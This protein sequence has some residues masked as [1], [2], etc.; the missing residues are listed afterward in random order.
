MPLARPGKNIVGTADTPNVY[1]SPG[2]YSRVFSAYDSLGKN[3]ARMGDE[4]AYAGFRLDA[5]ERQDE[6]VKGEIEYGRMYNEHRA[7]QLQDPDYASWPEKFDDWSKQAAARIIAQTKHPGA[8]NKLADILEVYK[9]SYGKQTIV[10]ASRLKNAEI[11]SR[12]PALV[13]KYVNDSVELD[14]KNVKE[15]R[16]ELHQEL[17]VFQSTGTIFS[18]EVDDYLADF[19]K[20]IGPVRE[21]RI[22]ENA[23]GQVA[24]IINSIPQDN[25]D[26]DLVEARRHKA[27]LAVDNLALALDRP[28]RNDLTAIVKR[29]FDAL[30][31]EAIM[32]RKKAEAA[33]EEE[34][35]DLARNGD[36]KGID[37]KIDSYPFDADWKKKQFSDANS[38]ANLVINKNTNPY[39]TRLDNTKYWNIFNRVLNEPD[40]VSEDDMKA[41]VGKWWTI[42]DYKELSNMKYKD[43][44]ALK[45]PQA[46]MYFDILENM[47]DADDITIEEWHDANNKLSSY[48]RTNPDAAPKDLAERFEYIIHPATMGL[49]EKMIKTIT[50]TY[51]AGLRPYMEEESGII[52]RLPDESIKEYLARTK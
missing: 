17:L 7:S 28:Q 19:D 8:R 31:A 51:T 11:R 49:L 2:T 1:M 10:S 45:T 48:I 21:A 37:D 36:I 6:I 18:G 24:S 47:A 35:W 23:Y 22:F 3:I 46:K 26:P 9:N 30:E 41:G 13:G 12:L 20:G 38:A 43:D 16:K 29:H 32:R 34:I 25:I 50:S 27:D 42:E 40:K 39:T 44:E 14:D 4:F 52:K 15:K 33:A 5:A